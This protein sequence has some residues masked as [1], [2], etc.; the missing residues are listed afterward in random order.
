[1]R[2][3]KELLDRVLRGTTTV[4]IAG[5]D[6]VVLGADRRVSSGTYIF[7][8]HGKKIHKIDEH[9]ATTIAGVVADAQRLVERLRLETSI[10]RL[11]NE[12][13]MPVRSVATLASVLLFQMRPILIAH[14][15]VGGVDKEGPQL[16]SIDW[17]GTITRERFTSSG[18]GTP[19]AISLL[20]N[21]Y[22]EEM[23]LEEAIRLA[24]RA[25]NAAMRRDPGSGEG[26]DI[27]VV[28]AKGVKELG[29][30]EIASYAS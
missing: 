11:A 23:A 17:L 24:I 10:Y 18:S 6:F 21:E 12:V 13:P 30:E 20:E 16:Y 25:L 2:G 14:M 1:L 7:H 3:S 9:V 19:Y 5:R 15:L 28:S 29:D 22:R 4:G 8:K 27:A 26:I